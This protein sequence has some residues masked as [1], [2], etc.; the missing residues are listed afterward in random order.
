MDVICTQC[1]GLDVHNKSITA[2]RIAPDATGQQVDGLVERKECG[3]I[4]GDLL[5]RS[6]WL[7]KAG[8]TH[9]AMESPGEY[10]KPVLNRL[11]GTVAVLLVHAAHVKPVP[12]R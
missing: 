2:C 1:A 10:W 7:T 12:G 8:I 6:D 9:R 3:T 4:T 5:A 11:E